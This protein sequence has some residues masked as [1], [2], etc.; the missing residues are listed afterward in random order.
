MKKFLV[1]SGIGL[2]CI[3]FR[4]TIH[5]FDDIQPVP[6]PASP[7]RSGN[8]EKGYQ[9]LVTGDYLKSGIPYNYFKLAYGKANGEFIKR[10][11]FNA[12]ISYEYTAVKASNGEIVVAP[13]CLQC[14]A[15]VFDDKLIIGLGNSTVDFTSGQKLNP[16]NVVRVENFLKKTDPKK[17]E[18]AEPFLRAAKAV[19]A[20][21]HTQV[22]GV[23]A[24]DRLAA[25]LA[26]HRDPETFRWNPQQMMDIPDNVIP[27]DVPAW[28]L[29]K[30]KH[31]MFYNG[32]GRGDFGK[33]L[34]ASNLLTVN[35]TAESA[36]VDRH[37][38]DVLAY[39]N[40]LEPPPYPRQIDQRLAEE[41]GIIYIHNCAK[42]HGKPVEYPN[43]LIPESMVGTDSLLYKSNYQNPQFVDWFNRSWFAQGDHPARL[44]PF[45]GYIAPPLDG[46]WITAPYFHNGSVPSLEGVLNSKARPRYWSRNFDNPAFD[47]D[48]VGWKYTVQ[49]KPGGTTVY[50][51]DLPGYGNY[52][53]KFGD[54]LTERQRKALIEYLK[55]L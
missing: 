28:W 54:R 49:E 38:N 14:H 11:G 25:L 23:N 37:F 50:N 26:S 30:K 9:Y 55:T 34:M 47:Y 24:A 53:H 40:S 1:L 27:S 52:G 39:L 5:L 32:F 4:D 18:A 33:F 36:E 41:G 12:D 8:A 10:D 2:M 7:Q 45:N 19:G 51:T 35:D 29:L 3:A 20:Q 16:Q 46:I 17:Y 42:C 22:R 13:N 21:L 48:K 6:I 44:Q 43:L 31:G 15:Q